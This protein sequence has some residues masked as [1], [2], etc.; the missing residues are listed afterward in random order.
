M[1]I[2]GFSSATLPFGFPINRGG[3]ELSTHSLLSH[4]NARLDLAF[5][6]PPSEIVS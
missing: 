5:S 3:D 1:G 2:L 6:L 4:T